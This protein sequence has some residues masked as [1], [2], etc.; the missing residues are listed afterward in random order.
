MW[1]FHWGSSTKNII[2][3]KISKRFFENRRFEYLKW[4]KEFLQ[5]AN[6]NNSV[7]YINIKLSKSLN[8]SK[9]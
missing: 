7:N 4:N 8:K 5:E 2:S 3:T 6:I 9:S 1:L